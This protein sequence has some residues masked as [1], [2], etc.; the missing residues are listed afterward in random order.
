MSYKTVYICDKCGAESE[1][2]M[3]LASITGKVTFTHTKDYGPAIFESPRLE[4]CRPCLLK[5]GIELP[6]PGANWGQRRDAVV[7]EPSATEKFLE[8]TK[9]L[10]QNLIDERA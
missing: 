8:A 1:D 4:V 9:D 6:E 10:I 2:K 7:K 5:L 3:F